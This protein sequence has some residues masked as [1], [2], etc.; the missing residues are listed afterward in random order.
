MIARGHDGTWGVNG[1][2]LAGS[3]TVTDIDFGFSPAAKTLVLRRLRDE[4]RSEA[5]HLSVWLDGETWQPHL[6]Q[7]SYRQEAQD[8]WSLT[9]GPNEAPVDLSV[10]ARG[11]ITD[12]PGFWTQEG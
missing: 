8:H 10:D 12:Y 1:R 2:A 9:E 4:Q 6:R 3:E 11:F 7:Q 5:Q